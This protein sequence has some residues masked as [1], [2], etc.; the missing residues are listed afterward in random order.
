MRR[1]LTLLLL[2]LCACPESRRPP[3]PPPPEAPPAAEVV[4]PPAPTSLEALRA[5][6]E[7]DRDAFSADP[8]PARWEAAIAS[9][10]ALRTAAEGALEI[11]EDYEPVERD[12]L[13]RARPA[14]SNQR[15]GPAKDAGPDSTEDR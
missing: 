9:L 10:N 8:T 1:L 3:A 6:Y 15:E 7:A 4:T 2:T 13:V 12:E 11:L 14:E 5:A